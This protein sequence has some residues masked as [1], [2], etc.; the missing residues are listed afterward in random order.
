MPLATMFG[1]RSAGKVPQTRRRLA[2]DQAKVARDQAKVARDQAV[3]QLAR[4]AE[5][6]G[7]MAAQVREAALCAA[8]EKMTEARKWAAPQLDAAAHSIEQQLGPKLSAMLADAAAKLD[9]SPTK[10][11]SRSNWPKVLLLTG[12]AV[13]AAGF[14]MYRKN[15]NQWTESVKGGASDASHWM[16]DKAKTAADKVSDMAGGMKSR[17]EEFSHK[18]EPTS[19]TISAADRSSVSEPTGAARTSGV[20]DITDTAGVPDITDAPEK[21]KNVT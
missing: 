19:G 17:A 21:P 6:I 5:K 4:A 13:G 2:I 20:P 12:I 15:T 3:L 9:P 11:K 1:K 7:P 18:A 10:A 16:S 14:A 8:D